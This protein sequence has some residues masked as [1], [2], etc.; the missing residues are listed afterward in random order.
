[1]GEMIEQRDQR[2]LRMTKKNIITVK[3]LNLGM[4]K[5]LLP[6]AIY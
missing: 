1:M 5:A 2:M 6:L 4:L 3:L